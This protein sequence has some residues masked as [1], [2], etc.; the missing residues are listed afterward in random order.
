MRKLFLAVCLIAGLAGL[1][2][3]MSPEAA[4]SLARLS[5]RAD[6]GDPESMFRLSSVYRAG[7]DTIPADTVR[8]HT[9]LRRSAEAGYAPAENMLGYMSENPDTSRFWIERAAAQD[10]APAQSNLA[11]ML[12]G[13]D[14]AR[15]AR[16]L[17]A[18][19][20]QNLP[21]AMSLLGDLHREGRGVAKDTARAESL[22]RKAVDLGLQDAELRLLNMKWRAWEKLP[23]DTLLRMGEEM[24]RGKLPTAGFELIRHALEKA[25]NVKCDGQ[26]VDYISDEAKGE[27]YGLMGDAYATGRGTQY[28]YEK[29]L[30]SYRR[31]AGLGNA[32]ARQIIEEQLQLFPDLFN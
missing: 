12:L 20:A 8:W 10:Y 22:Y 1:L 23:A 5:E 19:V 3:A 26:G 25:D 7:Y 14:D 30:Q 32:R 28:N 6:A 21:E 18:A 4:Q 2:R 27:G 29:A 31:A 16:L 11:F 17:E 13:K 9:L 24:Y 15:A